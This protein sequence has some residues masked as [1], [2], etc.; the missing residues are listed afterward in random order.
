MQAEA[1]KKQTHR[2]FTPKYEKMNCS[3][4]K[5]KL[6]RKVSSKMQKCVIYTIKKLTIHNMAFPVGEFSREGYKIRKVFG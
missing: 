4:Q 5:K 2:K 6:Q 1:P 3:K